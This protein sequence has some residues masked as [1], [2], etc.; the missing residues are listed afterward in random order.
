MI[1]IWTDLK[2]EMKMT[3]K[4]FGH[5]KSESNALQ[6]YNLKR[7]SFTVKRSTLFLIEFCSLQ[8]NYFELNE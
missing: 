3:V 1:E 7:N 8:R 5:Y 2:M 6:N 4:T